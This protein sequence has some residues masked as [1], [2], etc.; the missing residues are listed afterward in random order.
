MT[1]ELSREQE[2]LL[3][4]VLASGQFESAEQFINYSLTNALVE[5]DAFSKTMGTLF[6]KP[7][8]QRSAHPAVAAHTRCSL[9]AAEA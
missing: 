9:A 5:N 6:S 8:A 3:E 7:Q 2:V 4:K 1:I